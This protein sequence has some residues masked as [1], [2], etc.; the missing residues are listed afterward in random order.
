VQKVIR[1]AITTSPPESDLVV[2]DI[3]L[4]HCITEPWQCLSTVPQ[5]SLFPH[6]FWA[7]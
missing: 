4:Y 6:I 7:Y 1:C 5:Q 3:F 2:C